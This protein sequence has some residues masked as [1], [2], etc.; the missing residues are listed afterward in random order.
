MDK[1]TACSP[2]ERAKSILDKTVALEAKLQKAAQARNP[3]NPNL[4]QQIRE[5]YEAIILEDHTFSEQHGVEL[6]LWQLHYKRICEFRSH[7]KAVLSS[8]SSSVAQNAKGPSIPDRIAKLKLQFR[9]FLSEATGFYH[10]MILKIRS[11][12][13]LPLGFFSEDQESQTLADK[14]VKK[15]AEFKKGLVFCHRCLIYL[16][17]LARY[18]GLYAEGDSKNREHAAASS[19][20]LQA[21]SLLPASG[22]PHH[23]LAIIASYS[24]DEFAATYRYFR[25]L[26]VEYPFPTARENLV[27]AFDKNRQNYAQLFAASKDS[28]KRLTG[29]GRGKGAHNS[30]KNANP[31]ANPGKDKVT[32]ASEMLKSFCIRFVHLNGILFTR[33]SLETFVDVLASTSSNLREL[34][35]LSLGEELSFGTDTSDSALFIVRLVT[36]LIFS[37]HNSKK[38]TEGQSYAEI[39]QRVEPARNSLTASFE[40]LGHVI[41]QCAQ[42]HDLSSSYFLPGVLVFVEWLACCPDIALGTYP[43]DK[44]TAVRNTFWNRCV[45]FFNQILS[46][47]PMFIDDVEDETC[48]SSMSMYD[49]RETE[50]RLALWE[51]YELRGFLPLLPAQTILDFSRKHSFGTEGPKEKKV[52]IKR[53]LA[54]G[55]ALTSVIKVDQNHVF[56]DSK[57]KKFLVG[58]KPSDD[59]LDSHSSPLEPDNSLQDNQAMTNLNSPVMQR[60]QQIYLDEEDDDEVIVFKPL[61]SE[62]TREASDKMFVPNGGFSKPDQVSTLEDIK[63]LSGSDAAF[64]DNLLLQARGNACIQV[65]A[66]VGSNILGHLYPP[67]QS[68]AMQ[69]VQAQAVHPQTAQSLASA[70]LQLMQS[71]VAQLQQQAVHFQQTQAQVSHV[72]PA[73]S[74]SASLCGSTWLPEE[75]A[76]VASSLSGFPQMGNGLVTRSEMQ[77]NHGASYYPTH[78]LPIHQ[79]FNVNG[80]GGMQYSHSR[81][82]EAVLPPKTDAVP[83][84][85]AISDALGVQSSIARKNPIGRAYLGPPPGFNSVPSKLQKE[86]TPASDMSGNNLLVDDYSWLDGYQS[87]SSRGTGLNST[88]NYASAG[89]PEHMGTS[90]GLNGLA[91]FPFPGK[92]VPT[93]QVQADFPYFQNPQNANFVKENH[94]SAQL[95]EQY[96]GHPSWSGRHFV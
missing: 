78:S 13:G 7:I 88:L 59:L 79:S 10:D 28:S 64:H 8:S 2:R 11:K 52:R 62:K 1:K 23:Q 51:D 3:F 21:A 17:D 77:G 66:S 45:A 63:A 93:S 73:Q 50:N 60:D 44:Q 39:V 38:E 84:S 24:G 86:P 69:Q 49:E 26:A 40:L 90:N 14:D 72:P 20:Y 6:T 95:P 76:S 92:Q 82:P 65:P 68:Q 33:T 55:K 83:S 48:F 85:G 35:S 22:N 71:Q 30:S 37:V 87:Q 43:D 12:Y 74:Q 4:W 53:I 27:V 75:A 91:N 19:Y 25:S 47:G 42:L 15:L 57:K 9:T 32:S 81:T 96:Q 41:E 61:V 56:F 89:K 29:K 67:S 70:R 34:I 31:V 80:I 46:L 94:Q 16:G 58:V 54:A 5:N 36:I 18:K